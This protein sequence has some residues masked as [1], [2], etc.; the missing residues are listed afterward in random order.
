LG[1]HL[2]NAYSQYDEGRKKLDKFGM[3]LNQIQTTE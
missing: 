1:K 2:H 3:Q